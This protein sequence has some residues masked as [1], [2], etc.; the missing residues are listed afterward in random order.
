[1]EKKSYLSPCRKKTLSQ[2]FNGTANFFYP[3]PEEKM[4]IGPTRPMSLVSCSSLRFASACQIPLPTFQ[5]TSQLFT[6]FSLDWSPSTSL[7]NEATDILRALRAAPDDDQEF[8]SSTV[9]GE[10]S[11]R[12]RHL[13]EKL[14]AIHVVCVP[15]AWWDLWL[16]AAPPNSSNTL[17]HHP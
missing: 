2:D 1:M 5:I 7:G 13:Q 11:Q 8:F 3:P 10:I 17:K 4:P 14:A 15:E 6:N 16:R 12:T 9:L